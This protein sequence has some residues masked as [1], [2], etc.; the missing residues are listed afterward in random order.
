MSCDVALLGVPDELV[1]G[2]SK[3]VWAAPKRFAFLGVLRSFL[4]LG[5]RGTCAVRFTLASAFEIVVFPLEEFSEVLPVE[6]KI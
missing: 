1:T 6:F 2:V 5:G 4:L 3:N